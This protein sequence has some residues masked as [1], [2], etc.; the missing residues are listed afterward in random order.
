LDN[1]GIVQKNLSEQEKKNVFLAIACG[2]LQTIYSE[3]PG[4]RH[5]KKKRSCSQTYDKILNDIA[6]LLPR[7]QD[8]NMQL[9]KDT[10]HA[11]NVVLLDIIKDG[12]TRIHVLLNLASFCLQE[13]PLKDKHW[14]KFNLLFDLWPGVWNNKG[15]IKSGERIFLRIEAE[16]QILVAQRGGVIL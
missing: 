13:L 15:D 3:T 2:C 10:I 1:L 12:A 7:V 16:V 5:L 6:P 14:E 8:K 9:F 11:S 4:P